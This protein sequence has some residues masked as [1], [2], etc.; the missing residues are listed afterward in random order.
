VVRLRA[1]RDWKHFNLPHAQTL[2]C[3]QS[4]IEPS[5]T[6]N[7]HLDYRLRLIEDRT[8]LSAT[9]PMVPSIP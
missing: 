5:I 6:G 2:M 3:F 9:M 1:G 4:A 7:N 8:R